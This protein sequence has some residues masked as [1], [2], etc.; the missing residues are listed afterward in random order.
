MQEKDDTKKTVVERR[1][2]EIT[3]SPAK[4]RTKAERKQTDQRLGAALRERRSERSC[5]PVA[6]EWT[7]TGSTRRSPSPPSSPS[8]SGTTYAC[9]PVIGPLDAATTALL[10]PS[11]KKSLLR[12]ALLAPS[13]KK[14]PHE[15]EEDFDFMTM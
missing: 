9:G 7:S 1:G 4:Y 14:T 8:Y 2:R 13:P 15:E 12:A 3:R 5:S 10:A 11:P 6:M